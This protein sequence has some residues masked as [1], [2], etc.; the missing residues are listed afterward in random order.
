MNSIRCLAKVRLLARC[1]ILCS[2][3]VSLPTLGIMRRGS[4]CTGIRSHV[5]TNTVV[6]GVDSSTDRPTKQES[7]VLMLYFRFP[8]QTKTAFS[9]SDYGSNLLAHDADAR[10]KDN[11]GRTALHQ[12]CRAV[13]C[14]AVEVRGCIHR[15]VLRYA[16]LISCVFLSFVLLSQPQ[17]Q[18]VV[19]HS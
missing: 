11:H 17:R 7:S 3:H 13:D 19:R 14:F 5:I 18:R 2:T 16:R 4:F 1:Q 9:I 6:C 12:A 8:Q 15:T 10:A